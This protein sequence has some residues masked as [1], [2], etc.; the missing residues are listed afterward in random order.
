MVLRVRHIQSRKTYSFLPSFAVPY[1]HYGSDIIFEVIEHI[2]TST[3]SVYE[4]S[5]YFN[6]PYQTIHNWQNN[7]T[8][9]LTVHLT[10]GSSRLNVSL[11][12]ISDRE[13]L[14]SYYAEIYS[15]ISGLEKYDI[16]IYRLI[17]VKFTHH[18]PSIGF[19]RP[20]LI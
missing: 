19:F 10:E 18:Q 9:N 6:I 16:T 11:N 3:D 8:S 5:E 14:I 2:N 17:Q 13:Q 7:L 12:G 20:L 15:R 4:T 1:K